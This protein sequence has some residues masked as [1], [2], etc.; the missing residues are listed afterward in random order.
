MNRSWVRFPPLAPKL[1]SPLVLG[2]EQ[3]SELRSCGTSRTR[4]LFVE[5]IAPAELVTAGAFLL[6]QELYVRFSI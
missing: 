4:G 1:I 3:S 2:Y 6:G 5:V